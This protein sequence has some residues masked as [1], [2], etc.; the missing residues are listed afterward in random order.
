MPWPRLPGLGVEK[1]L[2]AEEFVGE[3]VSN[4]FRF[5]MDC[6]YKGLCLLCGTHGSL[7]LDCD[8]W[9]V[10]RGC[11]SNSGVLLGT[12]V[13]D[14]SPLVALEAKSTLD[15]LPL[16]FVGECSPC[17]CSSYIHCVRVV[18]SEGVSPLWFCCSSSSVISPDSFFEEDVFLLVFLR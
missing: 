4:L 14:V 16:F 1:I 2:F 8:N 7:G 5:C 12:E 11:F 10:G 18:V 17:P 9:S 13:G 3:A 6:G 15:S